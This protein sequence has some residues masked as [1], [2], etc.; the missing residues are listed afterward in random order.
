MTTIANYS[1]ANDQGCIWAERP[2]PV[3]AFA[4]NLAIGEI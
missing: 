3:S 1:L 2:M 4:G